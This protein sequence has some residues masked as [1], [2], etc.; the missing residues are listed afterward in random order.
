[1][2]INQILINLLGNAIKFTQS[3]GNILLC[4]R[5]EDYNDKQSKVTF[6]VKDDGIGISSE[7]KERVFHA[8]EQAEDDTSIHYG[9]TGLGLAICNNLVKLMGS[10][11]ELESDLGKGSTFKFTLILE[12]SSEDKLKKKENNNIDYDFSGKKVLLVEDND[13]NIEIAKTI[14][15]MNKFIVEV[16]ENGQI[17]VDKFKESAVGYYDLIL[18]DIRMPI[19]D[20]LT[21]TKTIRNLDKADAITVPI[22]A[23]S[24]NAFDEDMK[25]SIE[26]G[27]N[28][29]ISKPIDLN[30][31]YSLLGDL[32]CK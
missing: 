17:A 4:V 5:E 12:K 21:A 11:I 31:L 22:V 16:A 20:G 30:K 27:M 18:M 29:H 1:M 19:M 10:N 9:G 14:L 15:E 6:I 3:K 7:N 28:G 13:L 25:K 8:F 24:A 26:S 23:M 2:R 32:L